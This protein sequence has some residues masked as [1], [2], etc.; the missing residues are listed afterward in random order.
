MRKKQKE[1]LNKSNIFHRRLDYKYPVIER[2]KGIYLF[3]EEGNKYI[4]G[5][6]GALVANLGHGVK[7]IAKKIGQLAEKTSFLHASQF[8]TRHMEN[9][10]RKLCKVAPKGMNKVYFVS[11]G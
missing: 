11:G 4:D 2:G 3:D 10:A 6:G 9:Y 5:V 1:N 8:T 7:E